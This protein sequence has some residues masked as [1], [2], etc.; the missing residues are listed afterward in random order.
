M[1]DRVKVLVIEDEAPIRRFLKASLEAAGYR[2]AE[3]ARGED[4]LTAAASD[5]PD[6]V[7]LDLGLPDT[8]G[9]DV[10]RRL[11]E[12][13]AVPVLVLS[14]REQESV[15][16]LALDAG[17]DDYLCK[18]FGVA[19]LHA[20]LRV[21]LRRAA[22][23]GGGPEPTVLRFGA[24]EIDL[25]KRRVLRRGE[26]VHLTPIEYRLLVVLARHA[27]RVLTHRQILAA[28]WGKDHYD[29]PHTVRV[30]AANLRRKIEDD[31]ARPVH[32]C[33]EQGVGYRFR[34]DD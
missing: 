22:S 5:P 29:D 32:L 6:V 1:S 20:R 13:S 3:A 10:L 26:E 24:L 28:V 16:V 8:D 34:D 12:W 17:A 2:Y 31:P 27:G 14:A 7:I 11:R 15:K 30:H 21:I 4:G 33:T 19:E 25:V 23:S 18:P 9:L